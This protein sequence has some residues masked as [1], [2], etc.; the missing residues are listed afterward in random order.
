MVIPAEA[1]VDFRACISW[2]TKVRPEAY[3]KLKVNGVL[4][5]I[6]APHSL[7]AVPGFAQTVVPLATTF[8]P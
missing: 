7:A 8:Q 4:A 1:A 5:A 3:C 6:P 2:L